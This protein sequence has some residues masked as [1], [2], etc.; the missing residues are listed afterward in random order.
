MLIN[1][2]Y[3][4]IKILSKSSILIN[5]GFKQGAKKRQRVRIVITGDDIE[6]NDYHY[7][8]YDFVKDELEIDKVFENFSECKKFIM[9]PSPFTRDLSS[10]TNAFSEFLG[11]SRIESELNVKENE[12]TPL[13]EKFKEMDETIHLGDTVKIINIDK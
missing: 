5:Y 11:N 1:E 7:G 6:F 3:K 10:M 4:V 12:I 8:T 9:K 2:E 13:I